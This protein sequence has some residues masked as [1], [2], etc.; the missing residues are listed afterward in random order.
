MDYQQI[1]SDAFELLDSD[2]DMEPKSAL[3]QAA[4]LH[5]VKTGKDMEQFVSWALDNSVIGIF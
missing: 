4:I 2:E 3:K 1:L 5:G